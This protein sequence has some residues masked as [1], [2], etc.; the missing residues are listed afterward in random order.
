MAS[1]GMESPGVCLGR[2]FQAGEGR[3]WKRQDALSKG[4][5]EGE[6]QVFELQSHKF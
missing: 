6:G 5:G 3:T 4:A 1:Q 2:T